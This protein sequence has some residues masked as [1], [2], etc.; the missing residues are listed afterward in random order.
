MRRK[1]F[2]G[3]ARGTVIA[4]PSKSMSHRM[5]ICAGCSKENSMIHHLAYS[6]D[7]LATLDCLEGMGVVY[8]QK[9]D[10][11]ELRG[12][13]PAELNTSVEVCCRESGSTLR[14]FIPLFLLSAQKVTLSGAPRL[15]QRPLDIYAKICKEQNLY[16]SQD[17]E[18]VT[19]QGPLNAGKFTL[20]GNI[21]SQFI[22]GLLFALPM[23]PQESVIEIL[24]PVESKPYIDMT[25]Q[26][27]EQF[28]VC[29]E[30]IGETTLRIPGGQYYRGGDA[31]VEGDYSNAAFFDAFNFLGGTV[32]VTGLNPDS[33]QG[34]Q[35]YTRYFQ[36]LDKETPVLDISDCP[37][38]APILMALAVEKHG[39]ILTGTKRL[40]IKE[41]DRGEVMAAELRKFGARITVEEDRILIDSTELHAPNELLFGHND[42]RIV[43][44]LAVLASRYGGMIDDAQA[45]SK[46]FPDFFQC[47]ANVGIQTEEVYL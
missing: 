23:L 5:L 2:P 20:P 34:D 25:L 1:I 14:F 32:T 3:I 7:I 8:S 27:L 18:K 15:L 30:W 36:E 45:V 38:L 6:Q 37:D 42:H 16:F 41:S 26:A 10:C 11:L 12:K 28:G 21:S 22:S 40:K 47:L 33:L 13:C 31:T 29:A 46:S 19:L 4:P 44:A 24:P 39:A 17:A 43:M 9:E 35:I